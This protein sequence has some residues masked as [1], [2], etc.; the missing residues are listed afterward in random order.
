[1]PHCMV[2]MY[3]EITSLGYNH[4]PR[5][6]HYAEVA[7]HA[8]REVGAREDGPSFTFAPCGLR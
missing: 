7:R 8:L 6:D 5:Y 3:D 2:E 4:Q 1:M